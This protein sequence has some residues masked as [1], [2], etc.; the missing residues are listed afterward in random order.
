M[1]RQEL[2][3]AIIEAVSSRSREALRSKL[4]MSNSRVQGLYDM[5]RFITYK[6]PGAEDRHKKV[7]VNV[8]SSTQNT[9]EARYRRYQRTKKIPGVQESLLEADIT[10]FAHG[11]PDFR[12]SVLAACREVTRRIATGTREDGAY[13]TPLGQE[14]VVRGGPQHVLMHISVEPSFIGPGGRPFNV[15]A[16][17]TSGALSIIDKEVLMLRV[18]Y[19]RNRILGSSP[20]S[21]TPEEKRLRSKLALKKLLSSRMFRADLYETLSHEFLHYL[22]DNNPKFR[23]RTRREVAHYKDPRE[24]RAILLTDPLKS[25]MLKRGDRPPTRWDDISKV[26]HPDVKHW[27]QVEPKVYK[28]YLK[29]LHRAH[30]VPA[31]ERTIYPSLRPVKH[32]R[33]VRSPE[34]Q[35]EIPRK[36]TKAEIHRV[37]QKLSASGKK[38]A[39]HHLRWATRTRRQKVIRELMAAEFQNARNHNRDISRGEALRLALVKYKADPEL[40]ASVRLPVEKVKDILW[41]YAQD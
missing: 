13:V 21:G 28:K 1:T 18:E 34:S 7:L 41:K 29:S 24:H 3:E 8:L 40:R 19:D 9:R 36:R 33:M 11:D 22:L 2:I 5:D 27:R 38:K 16:S 20:R 14:F 15:D 35:Q 12:K 25:A 10:R 26:A 23:I 4:G 30:Q 39:Q 31:K 32:I 17:I 37:D 6:L